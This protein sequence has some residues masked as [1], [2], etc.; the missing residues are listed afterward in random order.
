[1]QS[2]DLNLLA[3]AIIEG[4]FLTE[5]VKR[6]LPLDGSKKKCAIYAAIS[7]V[8]LLACGLSVGIQPK[9][10]MVAILTVSV[11]TALYDS[12]IKSVG[13][14]FDAAVNKLAGTGGGGG[15]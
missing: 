5:L 14:V 3:V 10:V 9:P 6:F 11:G 8:F 2:I 12:V 13:R 7:V 15:Q 1:M 4:V